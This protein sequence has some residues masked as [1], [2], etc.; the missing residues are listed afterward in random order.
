MIMYMC[1]LAAAGMQPIAA[2][3]ASVHH[4]RR[5]NRSTDSAAG[6]RRRRIKQEQPTLV[7]M[8]D[9]HSLCFAVKEDLAGVRQDVAGVKQD[10]AEKDSASGGPDPIRCL[11]PDVYNNPLASSDPSQAAGSSHEQPASDYHTGS[12]TAG[13]LTAHAPEVADDNVCLSN[14]PQQGS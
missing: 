9:G 5:R 13:D 2:P 1:C 10:V 8:P 14:A 7:I 3:V 12:V 6:H 4:V 11:Y